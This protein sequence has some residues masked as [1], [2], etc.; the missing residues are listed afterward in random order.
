MSKVGK[1]FGVLAGAL[2]ASIVVASGALSIAHISSPQWIDSSNDDEQ[3]EQGR[4]VRIAPAGTDA[5]GARQPQAR[6]INVPDRPSHWIGLLGR[7]VAH[8]LVREHLRLPSGQGLVVE[9]VVAKGPAAD[10]GIKP[11]DILLA[12]NGQ[13][14]GDVSDLVGIIRDGKD[15]ALEL[16]LI[17]AGETQTVTV[18]PVERPKDYTASPRHGPIDR[19]GDPVDETDAEQWLGKRFGRHF[20]GALPRGF[21]FALPGSNLSD[22]PSG[23]SVQVERQNDDPPKITIRRGN[24]TWTIEGDDHEAI[25]QLPED[26]QPYVEGILGGHALPQRFRHMVPDFGEGL[27]GA[28]GGDMME[29]L[30]EMEQRMQELQERLMDRSDRDE[31]TP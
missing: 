26:L 2:V 1:V 25:A 16:E 22:I 9:R 21:G 3:S 17:R 31:Q 13:P 29:R 18:T 14:I 10:A 7:P 12:A 30:N 24:D 4:V 23:V 8:P 15:A 11:L 27:G 20:G 19:L 28:F 6:V 5:S